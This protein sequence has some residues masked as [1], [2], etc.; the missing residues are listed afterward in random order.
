MIHFSCD[1]DW[2]PE[3]VVADALALFEARGIKCTVFATHESPVLRA[4]RRDLFEV[5]VHPNFNPVLDGKGGSADQVLDA[6]LGMYPEARGVRCH[7]TA[8]T[9]NLLTRFAQRG[10]VYESNLLL[11]YAR[12]LRPFKLPSGLVRLPY[13]FEDDVHFAYGHGFDDSGLDLADEGGPL[14]VDFHPIHIFLNT[15]TEARYLAARSHYQDPAGLLEH[16]NRGPRPGARDLLVA[17]LDRAAAAGRG[18]RTLLELA[19]DPAAWGA[20]W[21]S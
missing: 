15:E 10:L 12:R 11:P 13:V 19:L 5:G 17:L 7:S 8:Q 1:V 20:A 9:Y 3:A 18:S 4:A 2:A 21:T 14:I 16:R 6:I